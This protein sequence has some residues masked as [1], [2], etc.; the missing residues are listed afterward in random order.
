MVS[1]KVCVHSVVGQST[2][3][4][5]GGTCQLQGLEGR[6]NEG[7]PACVQRGLEG[8]YRGTLGSGSRCGQC[9]SKEGSLSPAVIW[10]FRYSVIQQTGACR[11]PAQ[12]EA[13]MPRRMDQMSL[14]T[15]WSP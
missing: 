14:L 7:A 10:I 12:C 6:H 4:F 11:V 2:D 13:R 3:F 5:S 15:S 1:L 9:G 8:G